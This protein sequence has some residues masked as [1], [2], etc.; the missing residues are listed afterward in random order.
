MYQNWKTTQ[1]DILF[2]KVIIY[3]NGLNP[4]LQPET[5]Q[6]ISYLP[7]TGLANLLFLHRDMWNQGPH[8]AFAL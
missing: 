2:I 5:V 7:S 4:S 8:E 1:V 3:M 6:C